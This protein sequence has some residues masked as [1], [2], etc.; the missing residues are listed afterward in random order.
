MSVSVII[1]VYE[2]SAYVER[3]LQSVL[4]QTFTDIECIIVDDASPD[5]SIVKCERMISAYQGPIR[6]IIL[7][8]EKNRGLSAARNTGTA[9]ATGEYLYYLDSDDEIT[10]DCIEKLMACAAA[11][12]DVEMVQGAACLHMLEAEKIMPH[13]VEVLF[14]ESNDAAREAFNITKQ[15]RL[16]VW[17]KLL[18]RSFIEENELFCRE[19]LLYEDVL[20]SFCLLKHLKCAA[21][22]PDVTYHYW[23]RPHS[24]TTGIGVQ[25]RM[26]SLAKIDR[27]ILES[28]TPGHERE[29]YG[30]CARA[31]CERY[32]KYVRTVPEYRQ[33][34]KLCLE[35]CGQFG[36]PSLR[37][38]LILFRFFGWRPFGYALWRM[39][40]GVK[41]FCR[42]VVNFVNSI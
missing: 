42:K 36:D 27:E 19:G 23:Q 3:C 4:N 31:V 2:V 28:L 9:A 8:H 38:R 34:L 18:R 40:A 33:V 5:D 20:W 26:R 21:F 39:L 22:S 30:S 41:H 35:K 6:F 32:V 29:E 25:A 1:P 14:L 13:K 15:L 37:C 7:H 12:P 17:N 24:I 10:P 11:H 16:N